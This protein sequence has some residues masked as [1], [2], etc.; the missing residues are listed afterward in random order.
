MSL[1]HILPE[2]QLLGTDFLETQLNWV[3][4]SKWIYRYSLLHRRNVKASHQNT[5]TKRLI[6]SG[7][8]DSSLET[9]NIQ[10]TSLQKLNP[11]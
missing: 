2:Y 6:T 10:V 3:R 9:S 5:L 4:S 1:L 7:F 11:F 8:Y